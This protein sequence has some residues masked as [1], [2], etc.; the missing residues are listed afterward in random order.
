MCA[1]L[2]LLTRRNCTFL[3]LG[4]LAAAIPFPRKF[5][6]V[7]KYSASFQRRDPIGDFCR[8]QRSNAPNTFF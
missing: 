7:K 8:S 2:P 3:L 5:L 6:F 4:S 1:M